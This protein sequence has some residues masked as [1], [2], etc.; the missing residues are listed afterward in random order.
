MLALALVGVQAQPQ[1]GQNEVAQQSIPDAPKPQPALPNL[2]S[3][4]PGRG[5]DSSSGDTQTPDASVAP[6]A[7][8]ATQTPA[9]QGAGA[10]AS[11]VY[12]PLPGQAGEAIKT[13]RVNVDAVDVSFTVK[14]S[15]NR[16]VPGL[17]PRDIQVY[18]NGLLQHIQ[19]FINQSRPLSVVFVVDQS[20]NQEDMDRVNASLGAVQDAFSKYDEVAVLAY[21][22]SPKLITDFTGAQS[23]RLAQAVERAKGAG[24]EELLA[25]SLGGPMA[26]TT[27]VNNQNFDPNTAAVRGHSGMQLNP[28]REVHPLDDAILAAANMLR[29]R[30]LDYRRVIYV[31]SNGN[32]YGS[33]AKR[34][35]V[36]KILQ[37][38]NIEVD[39]TLVGT[40]GV[41]VLGLL[42]RV[43]L[44]F[45]MRDNVL[46]VYAHQTGGNLDSEFRIASIEKSFARVAEEARAKYTVGY[47]THEPFLD[48]KYR[49]L[50]I[51]V[52]H[53]GPDLTI[54]SPPGYYP[55]PRDMTRHPS[56]AAPAQ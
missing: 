19:V 26:Q 2:R 1:A 17:E 9:A 21:N 20:M 13:L 15:K 54:I 55:R 8:V 46:P 6:V 3:V 43:H 38:D 32:E 7:P 47:T 22:K 29:S 42:D 56:A 35:Q 24:R 44:P 18:E 27:V 30:P 5:T 52:L 48:G 36:L 41:P 50:E 28:P 4:A 33:Q 11:D 39:G 37:T 40:S 25:G 23:P 53:Y 34:A 51:K 10:G 16:L 14:D 31:I 49:K 12:V 45:M